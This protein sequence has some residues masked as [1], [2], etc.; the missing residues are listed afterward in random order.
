M[1]WPSLLSSALNWALMPLVAL[2]VLL[3]NLSKAHLLW[4]LRSLCFGSMVAV[5]EAFYSWL[6]GFPRIKFSRACEPVCF[7]SGVLPFPSRVVN[8]AACSQV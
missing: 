7:V 5:G 2:V 8:H 4:A 6:G 3:I 1:D